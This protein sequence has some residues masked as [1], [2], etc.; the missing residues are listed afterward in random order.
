MDHVLH[1]REQA[2]PL[3]GL[4]VARGMAPVHV[5]LIARVPTGAPPPRGRPGLVLVT[6]P[7][8]ARAAV[9]LEP[10]IRGA[11]VVAV[12]PATA[13]ALAERG[14]RDVQ[15][16]AG[17]GAAAVAV[18]AGLAPHRSGALWHIRGAAT[19]RS[20]S[21][22]L[23]AAGLTPVPWT[24]YS[25]GPA[26]DAAAALEQAPAW[27]VACFASGSAARVYVAAGGDTRVRV[28]VIGA[29]T[30]EEARRAGL[31]VHA[32]ARTPGMPGLADAAQAAL[33]APS[34]A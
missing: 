32:V 5:P 20:V 7:A 4:L 10:A 34:S 16:G 27:R 3:Q 6:S 30:A 23:A 8:G 13:A 1:T 9:D 22:A 14:V 26:P 12:G 29:D 2:E 19:S 25:T 31:A 11:T 17:G 21:G 28:A 33:S 15:V 24:V 18:L